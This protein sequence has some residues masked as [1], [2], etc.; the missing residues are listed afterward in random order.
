[1]RFS[2]VSSRRNKLILAANTRCL[3]SFAPDIVDGVL[4]DVHASKKLR[5]EVQ[6]QALSRSLLDL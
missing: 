2:Y 1:V 4:P 5:T 3:S 6:R